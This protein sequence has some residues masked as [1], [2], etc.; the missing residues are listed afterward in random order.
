MSLEYWTGTHGVARAQVSQGLDHARCSPAQRHASS[1]HS[2][3]LLLSEECAYLLLLTGARLASTARVLSVA[4]RC[5]VR[6]RHHRVPPKA[7]L[8][9]LQ[10]HGFHKRCQCA[11]L[12]QVAG[13]TLLARARMPVVGTL[14]A[15]LHTSAL[16]ASCPRCP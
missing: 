9:V 7:E 6:A 15:S 11:Q 14:A 16:T 2:S 5:T 13:H 10:M 1:L 3:M 12:S 4:V 8:L